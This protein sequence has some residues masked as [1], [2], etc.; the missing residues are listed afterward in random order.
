M[1]RITLVSWDLDGTLYCMRAMR[2][3][4]DRMLLQA[5][6]LPPW[7]EMG[8]VVELIRY[9]RSMVAARGDASRVEHYL[10]SARGQRFLQLQAHWISR[11]LS[12][13]GL[14]PETRDVIA[15]IQQRGV[16]QIVFSDYP[17]DEKL[18]VLGLENCMD[19]VYAA[20]DRYQVKPDRRAFRAVWDA[21]GVEPGNVLHIGDRPDTDGGARDAGAH[22]LILGRD[23]STLN[24]VW[25]WLE[26]RPL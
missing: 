20:A 14:R 10:R 4:L 17:A 5:L 8:A 2:R 13:C 12:E 26:A 7:S 9:Q 21:E 19:A 16:R 6:M 15:R 22:C 24:E 25:D 23:I 11:A 3:K 18:Q 1:H